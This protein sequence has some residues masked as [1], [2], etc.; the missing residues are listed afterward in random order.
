MFIDAD[1]HISSRDTGP[2]IGVDELLRRLDQVGVDRAICWPMVSYTREMASDN[3]AIY[4]GVQAHPDRLIPFGG[5]NPLLGL[6]EAKDELKRCIEEYGVRGVKLNGARDGYYIDDPDLSLPLVEMIAEAGLVLAFHCGSNDF[7]KTHP[8][9]I[10]KISDMYPNLPIMIIHMGGSGSP[11][12]SD[13]VIEY[14]ARYPTWRLIDSEADYRKILKALDVLGPERICYGSD[15]PFCPMRYEW[16]I[17]QAVYQDLS[18]A[19]RALVLG[20]NIARMLG[21]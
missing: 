10:A 4:Q 15:T 13:A 7:E 14:A 21:L 2:G 20:G 1:C 19:D 16:G 8:F 18:E 5:V 11:D 17:R 9:R 3:K 12:M 6:D